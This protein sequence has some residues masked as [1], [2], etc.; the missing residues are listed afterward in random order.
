MDQLAVEAGSGKS[1]EARRGE[2][3]L[4]WAS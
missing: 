3:G 1:S 2:G 4:S